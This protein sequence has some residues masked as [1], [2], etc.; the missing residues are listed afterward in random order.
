MILSGGREKT[1]LNLVDAHAPQEDDDALRRLAGQVES[2]HLQA[3]EMGR[4]LAGHR[5]LECPN[6]GLA[7]DALADLTLRVVHPDRPGEDCGLRFE[8]LDD[9]GTDW[10]CPNCGTVFGL[11]DETDNSAG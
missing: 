4:M 8:C 7:E 10:T 3:E 9:E 1:T 11:E 6:C 5:L 2:Y